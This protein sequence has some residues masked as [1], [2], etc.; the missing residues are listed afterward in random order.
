[1]TAVET[2]RATSEALGRLGEQMNTLSAKV[3][4]IAAGQE[5]SSVLVGRLL[6][7]II[8]ATVTVVG[9][10]IAVILLGG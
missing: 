5:T 10:A 8:S 6:V 1:M 3:D 2:G 7:G 4:V 9:A